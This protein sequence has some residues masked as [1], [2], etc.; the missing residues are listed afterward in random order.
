MHILFKEQ[1]GLEATEQPV[2]LEQ[3]PADLVVLSFSDSDLN[4]FAAGWRRDRGRLPSLRLA[5][6]AALRHPLAV[7]TYLQATLCHAKAVLLRLIGG[8]AY[9][10]YGLAELNA[11]ARRKGIALAVI[12]A[13]GR[14]DAR[15][16]A[17]FRRR[18][19]PVSATALAMAGSS[20]PF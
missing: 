12:P 10:S 2:D 6:L 8:E 13:D 16:E 19:M 9:W 18:P 11:L 7:D 17:Q 5:N 14:P 15:L 4:A 3:A 1:H 20:M